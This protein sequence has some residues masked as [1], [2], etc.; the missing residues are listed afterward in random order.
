MNILIIKSGS[1]GDLLLITP[2]IRRL[3]TEMDANVFLAIDENYHALFSENP[4]IDQFLSYNE[5]LTNL[6]KILTKY[7]FSHVIDLQN[8]WRSFRIRKMA[9]GNHLIFKKQFLKEWIY[10]KL[11]INLLSKSHVV[12]QY[13]QLVNSID[14]KPDHLGI[15]FYIPEKDEVENNWL[16]K[17]H[18]AGYAALAINAK[19]FT[20][21]LPTN[22]LIEL[23]DRINK[24]IVL[25]G[26]K[27]DL[28]VA[29]EVE[30]FFKHGTKEQEE[31]IE[32]LNKKTI[33]FN[34]CGKFN[35]NQAASIIKNARWVFAYDNDM[36]HVASAFN[37]SLYTIW[38]N[39]TPLFGK[40]PYQSKFTV[41]ENNK[42]SCRPCTLKGF[43]NCPKGHFKCMNEVTFDFY[44]PD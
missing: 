5:K 24:P 38:G 33:I 14:I 34:A 4:Y 19:H 30:S 1:V 10:L 35:F 2:I 29:N 12:D 13:F 8:S 23:C 18:Q 32:G 21:K 43:A 3:K 25:V 11:K 20:Q 44:L 9:G 17:S 37:K 15:D 42:L 27:E 36:M 40:Y 31:V 41:F 39:T 22:R 6:R 16:P 28:P 7:E 26:N